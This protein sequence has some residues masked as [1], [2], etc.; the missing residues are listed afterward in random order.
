MEFCQCLKF[1]LLLVILIKIVRIQP[2]DAGPL[3]AARPDRP[4]NDTILN[5]SALNTSVTVAFG[6]R[7]DSRGKSP[8]FHSLSQNFRSHNTCSDGL[9]GTAANRLESGYFS[10]GGK[11]VVILPNLPWHQNRQ[12]SE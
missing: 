11:S 12:R 6:Q 5:S 3:T 2:G 7:L 9:T 8:S 1:L 4:T 10:Q